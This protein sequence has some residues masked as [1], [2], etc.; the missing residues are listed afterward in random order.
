MGQHQAGPAR[1]TSNISLSFKMS[2]ASPNNSENL[3]LFN[4]SSSINLTKLTRLNYPTWKATMLPYLKGQKVLGYVDG[5]IQKP[6]KTVTSTDGSTIPNPSY[7]IWETQDNLILSCI[8]S[9]LLDAV[10]A[11][12]AHYS[13][14]AEVWTALNS[15]FALQSRAK[16]V[17]VRSQLS[18][19]QKG[20]Q[21]ATD[22]FMTIKRLT[23]E[24]AIADQPLKCDDIVTY[25]LAGLRP[26]YDSLISMV[27]RRDGSLTLEEIY[28]MLLTCEARIQHNTQILTLPVASAN[29]A[30]RSQFS[31]GG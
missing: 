9:S 10:L 2:S 25:L 4:P 6:N 26:E 12:V 21:S 30:T 28:S 20:N 24:L 23:D 15:V 5:T 7:E 16:A 31:F 11:Q 14:S 13:T 27:S 8:N 19:L 1:P 18:N 3:P 22:Y 17:H 29:I